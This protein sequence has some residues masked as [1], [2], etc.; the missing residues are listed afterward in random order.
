MTS[1]PNL[2]QIL[3]C[4]DNQNRWRGT[5]TIN[6]IASENVMSK[7]AFNTMASDFEHRY[8]EGLVGQRAY[9]GQ[10]Y[11]DEIESMALNLT[12]EL[13]GVDLVDLRC[14]TA[15]TA[16]L[17]IFFALCKPKDDYFSLTVPSGAHISY[18]KYGSAGCRNLTIHDIPYDNDRFN[19]DVKALSEQILT[20]KPKLITLGGSVFLFPHP[21][22]EIAKICAETNTIIHYDGS[23]VLGLIAG[24]EFQQPLQEGADILLGSS[25]KTFP[26]PQGAFIVA[27]NRLLDKNP[28]AFTKIQKRIFPGLVSN[29]HLWRF[30]PLAISLLEMVKFGKEYA[31]QTIVNAQALAKYLD[32]EGICV[33]AKNL[34]YTKSHQVVVDVSEY[35]GGGVAAVNLEKANIICN[36]NTLIKDDVNT[37][38]ENPSGLRLGTQELTRWGMKEQDMKMIAELYC[39]IIINKEDPAQIKSEVLEFR[40]QFSNIHFS[41]DS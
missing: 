12:K 5:E 4:V 2:E 40:K 24:G 13:F 36:K 1:L 15:T 34:G 41:L 14:P 20:V 6:M 7:T 32:K 22:Q 17:A 37:A 16:N 33:M 39:R 28:K 21:V 3:Q 29:H 9:Q 38:M 18:R 27:H 19:I 30:P 23:H 10:Q 31:H 8:A 35:G 25:H 26:G 11:Q